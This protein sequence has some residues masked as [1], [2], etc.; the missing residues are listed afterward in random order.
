MTDIGATFEEL[1]LRHQ[2]DRAVRFSQKEFRRKF[3]IRL[4]IGLC[5]G[6][7]QAW[8]AE[9]RRGNDAI[10]CLREAT[11][12]LICEV[13]LSQT[14]SVY[15]KEFPPSNRDLRP[16]EIELLKLKYGEQSVSSVNSLCAL[17]G[18]DNCL[19]LDL[20][21]LHDL[22]VLKRWQFSHLASDILSAL[23][24]SG[25]PGLYVLL[26]RYWDS[27]RPSKERG[28]R[29]ALVIEASGS[30]R[31]YDP[32][33]GEV[34]FST[35]EHFSRWFAEYWTAQLWEYYLQRGTP[36]AAPVQLFAL[37][38]AFSPPA[39]EKSAALRERFAAANLGVEDLVL[40]LDGL[41]VAT[42]SG[43]HG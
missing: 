19:E 16:Y 40:W 4:P 32:L 24:K 10:I 33:W 21:L 36:P 18:V 7:V 6:L 17:F 43:G 1:N 26:A 5:A 29:S 25:H 13:L 28:H 14:R 39:A 8:W 12:T 35:F 31:F 22:P 9:S 34:S 38:G 30:C 23:E 3:D 42:V 41:R 27:K 2:V 11:P 15:L 37:G 20:A